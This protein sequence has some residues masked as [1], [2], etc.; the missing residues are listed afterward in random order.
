M[1]SP[2]DLQLLQSLTKPPPS[3]YP[4]V[5]VPPGWGMG[6]ARARVEAAERLAVIGLI[7]DS[8]P[9]GSGASDQWATSWPGLLRGDLQARHGNGGSGFVTVDLA[10]GGNVVATGSWDTFPSLGAASRGGPGG[11]SYRPSSAGNGATLTFPVNGS[12]VEVLL[13]THP[14]YGRVDVQ[15]DGGAVQQVLVNTALSVLRFDTGVTTPGQHTVKITA[16]VGMSEVWGVSGRNTTGL[17]IDNY[18]GGG[19]SIAGANFNL[20]TTTV[21]GTGTYT[22]DSLASAGTAG[23]LDA[24][25]FQVG[26]NDVVLG[27]V[28]TYE[29]LMDNLNGVFARAV[30]EGLT[31][32][33]PPEVVIMVEHGGKADSLLDA[34]VA[35]PTVTAA[36]RAMGD[37]LGAAVVDVW[38]AG[39]HSYK[40]WQ[41]LGWWSNGN[42]DLVHP[43]DRGHR[44]MYEM[45]RPLFVW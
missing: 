5:Y 37:G 12:K 15:V 28:S 18:S 32:P 17:L 10:N 27:N 42:T 14:T 38:A 39:H 29:A 25:I 3:S 23:T 13:K 9:K 24:L 36:L 33:T 8:I 21:S 20:A 45:I 43:E 6:W 2:T 16:A 31:D 44:F 4:F 1:V 26:I 30:N 22:T 40:Y 7:G 11:V 41:N 34:E 19:L 35:Y